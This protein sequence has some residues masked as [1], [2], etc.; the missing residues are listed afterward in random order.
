MLIFAVNVVNAYISTSPY[1]FFLSWN[2]VLSPILVIINIHH[3]TV[4]ACFRIHWLL[5][6]T[7]HCAELNMV[8]VCTCLCGFRVCYRH[9]EQRSRLFEQLNTGI[10]GLWF[11]CWG[12][13]IN[14]IE[15]VLDAC[16][17]QNSWYLK[18]YPLHLRAYDQK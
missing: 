7:E 13:Q 12:I 4:P 2:C 6:C 10:P 1:F 9:I 16:K 11:W 3:F 17:E 14:E 15:V 8:C 18:V 5:C